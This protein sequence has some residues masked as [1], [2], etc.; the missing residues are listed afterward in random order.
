MIPPIDSGGYSGADW[1]ETS[2]LRCSQLAPVR[3]RLPRVMRSLKQA[4]GHPMLKTRVLFLMFRRSPPCPDP[5]NCFNACER[6]PRMPPT[7]DPPSPARTIGT[8]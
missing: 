3:V 6:V 8:W 1:F 2:E 4:S 5:S 7:S